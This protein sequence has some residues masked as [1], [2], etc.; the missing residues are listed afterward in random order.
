MRNNHRLMIPGP[1][2]IEPEVLAHMSDPLTAHYGD[3][4]VDIWNGTV[5]N[6]KKITGTSGDIIIVVGS[7]HTAN[8]ISINSLFNPGD[9]VLT[10]NNGL[11]GQRLVDI[12]EA[13]GVE[14]TVLDKP[15]GSP[16]TADDIHEA[17]VQDPGLT[18]L[19]VVH[20]ET[21]T[22][23]ANP[24]E[25]LAAAAKE[26]GMLVMADT[27]ASLGGHPYKMD[28]WQVDITVCASQKAL[29]A[30]PG[31]A[32][33]AASE[34]AWAFMEN[35]QKPRGYMT[36]LQ[37]LRHFAETQAEF[38][39][40]P[41]T[42]PVNSFVAFRKSTHMI[43]EEGIEEVWARHHRVAEVV[44]KGVRE[45]GLRILAAEE[46]MC[47]NLTV[48]MSDDK[49][50]PMDYAEFMK[51]SYGMQVG[52]GLGDFMEKSIRIGHMG[53]NANLEAVVPCLVGLEQ[54][55][56]RNGYDVPRG[57]SLAGLD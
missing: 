52:L 14:Q 17:V 57:A 3:R 38:H 46:A 45:M 15:W 50:T 53:L 27:I 20:G 47:A 34:T 11:F 7:G 43:L 6:L 42:M 28:E 31:L 26:H 22:G 51:E 54:L 23:V 32:M 30:P 12:C 40:H 41:G 10:L 33:I 55:L 24:V 37:N 39:P 1:I 25:E 18:A 35:R 5:S 29:G 48:I 21:S 44:R 19:L 16:F 13:H 2:E 4:W 36:D 9:K 8:D 49:F 56:R